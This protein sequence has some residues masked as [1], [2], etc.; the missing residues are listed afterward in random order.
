MSPWQIIMRVLPVL[1]RLPLSA[2]DPMVVIL[3]VTPSRM[4][5]SRYSCPR[6]GKNFQSKSTFCRFGSAVV[7]AIYTTSTE[8]RCVAPPHQPAVV[9]VE[10]TCNGKDFSHTGIS[11]T[12]SE[13][14]LRRISPRFG[15]TLG[16]TSL[17]LEIENS[18]LFHEPACRFLAD[19]TRELSANGTCITPPGTEGESLIE[20]TGDGYYF[21]DEAERFRYFQEPILYSVEPADA[22]S[23]GGTEVSIHGRNFSNTAELACSFGC[24]SAAQWYSSGEIRCRTPRHPP[25]RVSLQVTTNGM[26]MSLSIL[27]FT[28][29]TNPSVLSISPA[30]GPFMWWLCCDD[31]RE[32]LSRFEPICLSLRKHSRFAASLYFCNKVVCV[33][34]ESW[35]QCW[36]DLC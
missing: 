6:F 5:T 9:P 13:T 12:F 8:V 24:L 14:L 2:Y 32:P 7:P 36:S 10:V 16:G 21:S 15:S 11:V 27:T 22:E 23:S 1:L 34:T 4:S 17:S 26:D 30:H 20:I 33:L 19:G 25:A 29:H 35:G 3:D 28:I 31:K 18:N